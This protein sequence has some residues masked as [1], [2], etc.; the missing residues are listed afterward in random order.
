MRFS[1]IWLEIIQMSVYPDFSSFKKTHIGQ[2][3]AQSDFTK[4]CCLVKMHALLKIPI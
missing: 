3:R 2:F 1:K 4:L